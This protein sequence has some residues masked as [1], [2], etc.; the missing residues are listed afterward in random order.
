MFKYIDLIDSF[1]LLTDAMKDILN[2]GE[3]PY[4]V[5]E[6]IV[7]KIPEVSQK[8]NNYEKK[9][10]VYTGKINYKFGIKELVESFMNLKDSNYRLVI[11][12]D[13]DAKSYV[14]EMSKKDYRIEYKGQVSSNQSKE[15]IKQ[16][17]VLVNPRPNNEKYTKS[18]ASLKLII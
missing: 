17:H 15:Y 8:N 10:I 1:V 2:V 3:R 5:V 7:D 12:G 14:D 11:C 6:G 18:N 16:A 4:I 9:I 13:G